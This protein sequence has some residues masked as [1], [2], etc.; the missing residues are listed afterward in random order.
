MNQKTP[1]ESKV[2]FGSRTDSIWFP[3]SK[4]VLA[5][6]M[7]TRIDDKLMG[8]T[9]EEGAEMVKCVGNVKQ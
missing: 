1:F 3:S 8:E 7:L 4:F 2:H 9:Q 5:S 6:E